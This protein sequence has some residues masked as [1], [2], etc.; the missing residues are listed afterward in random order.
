[1]FIPNEMLA[2]NEVGGIKD[3]NELI[4][5]CRKLSKIEKLSKSGN[6]KGKKSAK[7]KK[8]LKSGNSPNFNVKKAGLSFL[9]PKIRADFNRL[10]LTF[11][12]A[13]IF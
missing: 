3:G 8:L 6:L 2:A 11:I 12:K 9:T 13:L 4:E 7:P 1:M 5:K 10:W